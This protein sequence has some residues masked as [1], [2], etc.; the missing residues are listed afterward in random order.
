M[1]NLMA[2]IS[3]QIFLMP[4]EKICILNNVSNIR[5]TSPTNSN[6]SQFPFNNVDLD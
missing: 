4:L 5:G 3:E 2:E 1:I 6:I